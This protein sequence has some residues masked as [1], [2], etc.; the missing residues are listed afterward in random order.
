MKTKVVADGGA[1]LLVEP[2]A[3]RHMYIR[4]RPDRPVLPGKLGEVV[5]QVGRTARARDL[6][7]LRHPKGIEEDVQ[8]ATATL[9]REWSGHRRG[10][11]R[12]I[13]ISLCDVGR[14]YAQAWNKRLGRWV[15]EADGTLGSAW[16]IM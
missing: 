7:A 1:G 14:P 2:V 16:K 4:V 9:F 13:S 5:V 11:E 10:R 3:A 6:D 8:L 12:K 15:V